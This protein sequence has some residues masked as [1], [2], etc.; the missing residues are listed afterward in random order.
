M[1]QGPQGPQGPQMTGGAA[2]K[3]V[4]PFRKRSVDWLKKEAKNRGFTGYSKMNKES[5][6]NLLKGSKPRKQT[7]GKNGE[8]KSAPR[9]A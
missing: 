1:P 2:E 9:R 4:R 6:V 3:K 5:L 8:Q 7:A